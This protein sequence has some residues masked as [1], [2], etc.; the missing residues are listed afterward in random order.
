[1]MPSTTVIIRQSR[2]NSVIKMTSL[3]DNLS[4][5]PL[6]PCSMDDTFSLLRLPP[7]SMD[8]DLPRIKK[9]KPRQKRRQ[10]K[11]TLLWPLPLPVLDQRDSL[12]NGRKGK[13]NGFTV[14]DRLSCKTCKITFHKTSGLESHSCSSTSDSLKSSSRHKV[15]GHNKATRKRP[16]DD[17]V[18]IIGD[19]QKDKVREEWID[20]NFS[21][22]TL[23]AQ[24]EISERFGQTN[25]DENTVENEDCSDSDIE[26]LDEEDQTIQSNDQAKCPKKNKPNKYELEEDE[27]VTEDKDEDEI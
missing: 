5:L 16:V 20:K 21:K 25:I 1:M 23:K 22:M 15:T 17:E 8:D 9:K 4:M 18:E 24:R 26:I 2:P 27:V 14:F 3:E 6:L 10:D 7:H 12:G 19:T 13:R 11:W